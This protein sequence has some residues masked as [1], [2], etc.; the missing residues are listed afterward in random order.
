MKK[1]PIQ[2]TATVEQNGF[3]F[4][5]LELIVSLRR[6]E[7]LEEAQHYQN[8]H[9]DLAKPWKNPYPALPKAA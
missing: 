7:A 9:W 6:Q 2:K 1:Q 3:E 5:N 8:N 4:S